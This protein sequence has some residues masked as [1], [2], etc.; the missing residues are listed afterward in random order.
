MPTK[1]EAILSRLAA[2][3]QPTTG[4]TGR[5]FRSR[6]EP[7]AR[8]LLPALVVEPAGDTALVDTP[9]GV[10]QW[11]MTARVS[12]IAEGSVPDQ[13]ADPIVQDMHSR[14]MADTT[15]QGLVIDII[16][17]T[18]SFDLVEGDRPTGLIQADYL[19]SY[20]TA[21]GSLA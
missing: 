19:I 5:V 2:V 13:V 12:V 1:R 20:R 16:P 8:G 9:I 3:L 4:V 21:R 17:Q 7:L 15:L 6:V 11:S 14:I 10:I 18:V